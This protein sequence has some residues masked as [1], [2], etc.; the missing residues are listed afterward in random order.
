MKTFVLP[1]VIFIVTVIGMLTIK[2]FDSSNQYPSWSGW[3]GPALTLF[4][5]AFFFLTAFVL[6]SFWK[7]I[8]VYILCILSLMLIGAIAYK[9]Y[10]SQGCPRPYS[11][12][13]IQE[14][15]ERKEA[16]SS[17]DQYLSYWRKRNLNRS[18]SYE[19]TNE[20]YLSERMSL[21][22]DEQS[23]FYKE[24]CAGPR[25]SWNSPQTYAGF[26]GVLVADYRVLFYATL[27]I[28][29]LAPVIFIGSFIGRG[30]KK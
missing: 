25:L 11:Q 6:K 16:L 15:Q 1:I 3:L 28:V 14:F 20:D 27:W 17:Y 23:D 24:G 9:I 4:G 5:I 30:L 18:S 13:S 21:D 8:L 29:Y 7:T 10:K 2:Y 19:P 12:K 22:E 26:I